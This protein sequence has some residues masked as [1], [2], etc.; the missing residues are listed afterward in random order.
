MAYLGY[1]MVNGKHSGAVTLKTD[2]AVAKFVVGSMEDKII[3]DELD[4]FVLD[5]FGIFINRVS[6]A[7][8]KLRDVIIQEQQKMGI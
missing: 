7:Y 8:M 1:K 4:N 5:T 3:T 2:K 6:P